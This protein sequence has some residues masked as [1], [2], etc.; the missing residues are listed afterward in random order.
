MGVLNTNSAVRL[1]ATFAPLTPPAGR[2]GFASQSGGLG[3]EL[4]A[5]A[6]QVGLGI[7]TFVSM[8]N[9]A[10]VSGN[11]LIQYWDE[12]PDTDVILLYLES[13]GNPRKFARLARRVARR[14]PIIAVKSGR[15]V[16][17]ARGTSSHTAAL[18]APDVAV[19]AL[20]RQ[21]GVIRVDTL[22]QLFDVATVVL[23]QP[24]PVGRHVAIITNG[25]GPGILAADA[26]I[27]AGLEVPELSEGAQQALRSF[28]SP[29]AGVSNPVDLV[30]SATPEQYEQALE[31]L[32]GDDGIDACL[33]LFVSPLV[34]RAD[35]VERAVVRGAAA[36][37]KPVVACFLGRNGAL[38]LL[39]GR[40]DTRRIPSFAFP[41]AAARALGRA[42]EL[43]DWRRRPE[44]EI[45]E[46]DGV[47][48]DAARRLVA[49]GLVQHP[50]GGWLDPSAAR[51]LLTSVGVRVAPTVMV[52]TADA[53]VRTA[54]ELGGPIVLKAGS[55]A[56]VHKSDVGAVHVGLRTPD[57]VRGA[58][59]ALAARLG[60]QMGGAV[61]QPM[62]P[63]GVETIVGIT[64]DRSFG[65]LVLFGMGGFQ[66]ELVQDTALRI[67]PLTDLDAHELVRALRG[68]PLLFEYRNT[69][70]MAVDALE[71]LLLRV[72]GLADAIPEVAEL[73]CNPVI[74]SPTDATVVDVK[75]RLAPP[76][77]APPPGVRRLRDPA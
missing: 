5:R 38:D 73:D 47:D 37:P 9:K 67:L 28:L 34:T 45:P 24:L 48:L 54:S 43:A 20:F 52:D 59:D 16:A 71:D 30:A 7:S 32:L 40:A 68:S 74:V 39:P 65:S 75:V 29:A 15:T 77:P 69:P 58:F 12:D 70:P 22:E 2:V 64:R 72:G 41:E 18:A 11:D 62:L 14:K 10:D 4:L 26:C 21:A 57:E 42:A 63:P 25:G 23:H 60:E 6:D 13:F 31:T 53:A 56:I 55:G 49:A 76:D 51:D 35:D 36:T 19:D 44:G 33:V 8:G 1:N 46:L 17:G 50:E 3:I 61:V 66:A 27:A